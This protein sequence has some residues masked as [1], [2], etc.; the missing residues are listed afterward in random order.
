MCCQHRH[1]LLL[2]LSQVLGGGTAEEGAWPESPAVG[3]HLQVFLV[4]SVT[5][6]STDVP[7][8]NSLTV[9][10]QYGYSLPAPKDL[11]DPKRL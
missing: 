6:G 10:A 5:A 3:G 4:E 11:D 9:C 8:G 2:I 7:G 1:A